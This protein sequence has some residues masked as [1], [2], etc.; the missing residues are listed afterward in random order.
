MC[1]PVSPPSTAHQPPLRPFTAPHPE[2]QDFPNRHV[3]DVGHGDFSIK[4]M[5]SGAEEAE[6]C[7]H[8]WFC[9]RTCGGS[10]TSA[11]PDRALRQLGGSVNARRRLLLQPTK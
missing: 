3:H 11:L 10:Q 9:V 7:V 5:V 4:P 6:R 8:A 1:H 2:L